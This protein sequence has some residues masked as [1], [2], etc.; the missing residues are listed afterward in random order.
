MDMVKLA[1]ERFGDL[2]NTLQA[3]VAGFIQH[4]RHNSLAESLTF[5]TDWIKKEVTEFT[6]DTPVVASQETSSAA[7]SC[8][9]FMT[10]VDLMLT[11]V[12]LA[13]QNLV[14]RVKEQRSTEGEGCSEECQE[15][16]GEEEGKIVFFH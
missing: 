12:L 4:G 1:F 8:E 9:E 10:S 14:N 11:D 16:D 5:I 2:A 3:L 6:R 15:E 13:I 7:T